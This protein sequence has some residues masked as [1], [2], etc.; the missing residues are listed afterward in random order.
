M[1]KKVALILAIVMILGM[2]PMN[3]FGRVWH[4]ATPTEGWTTVW[5]EIPVA[6][7]GI[8]RSTAYGVTG[9]VLGPLVRPLDAGNIGPVTRLFPVQLHG[10]VSTRVDGGQAIGN[11]RLIDNRN[12]TLLGVADVP[13][14]FG[15][16]FTQSPLPPLGQTQNVGAGARFAH[17]EWLFIPEHTPLGGISTVGGF[18]VRFIPMWNPATNE[19]STTQGWIDLRGWSGWNT[20]E[21]PAVPATFNSVIVN[22]Q[23]V[24]RIPL[25]VNITAANA[26]ITVLRHDGGPDWTQGFPLINNQ[27]LLGLPEDVTLPAAQMTLTAGGVNN[28][29]HVLGINSLILTEA[30][31]NRIRNIQAGDPNQLGMPNWPTFQAVTLR[32]APDLAT[33]TFTETLPLDAGLEFAFIID[34]RSDFVAGVHTAATAALTGNLIGTPMIGPT[35][36]V[37]VASLLAA[38][39][40]TAVLQEA[41]R[42]VRRAGA[43]GQGMWHQRAAG[44]N[45]PWELVTQ[46]SAAHNQHLPLPATLNIAFGEWATVGVATGGAL[47]GSF[48]TSATTPAGNAV[49]VEQN[50]V[51]ILS[52]EQVLAAVT[53]TGGQ[54]SPPPLWAIASSGVIGSGVEP[55]HVAGLATHGYDHMLQTHLVTNAVTPGVLV[56]VTNTTGISQ[57]AIA[58]GIFDRSA[59][60]WDVAPGRHGTIVSSAFI[61]PAGETTGAVLGGIPQIL[62]AIGFDPIPAGF[63]ASPIYNQILPFLGTAT[64][65]TRVG[66]GRVWWFVDGVN[67]TGG[68]GIPVETAPFPGGTVLPSGQIE[69]EHNAIPWTQNTRDHMRVLAG[70]PEFGMQGDNLGWFTLRLVAPQHYAWNIAGFGSNPFVPGNAPI[71]VEGL[72]Q[73]NW[74][75]LQFVS[76][77]GNTAFRIGQRQAA[78]NHLNRWGTGAND[79][80][81]AQSN[82]QM[83]D[84]VYQN[85]L[86]VRINAG[87]PGPGVGGAQPL[88]AGIVSASNGVRNHTAQI[89][90]IEMLGLQ[91]FPN[92]QA[93]ISGEVAINASWGWSARVGTTPWNTFREVHAWG[94]PIVVGNRG[95]AE[96]NFTA[97]GATNMQTGWLGDRRTGTGNAANNNPGNMNLAHY[98][99]VVSATVTLEESQPGILTTNWAAPL[100]FRFNQHIDGQGIRLLGAVIN[101]G[102]NAAGNDIINNFQ[103]W[104]SAADQRFAAH[105][106]HIQ[107]DPSS[108]FVTL[109]VQSVHNI[110]HRA[111]LTARFYFSVEADFVNKFDTDEI[112]V[113]I[114]GIG[115]AALSQ[116]ARRLTIGHAVDPISV[117]LDGEVTEVDTDALFGV[118]QQRLSDVRVT[119]Y[120][121]NVLQ[122]NEELWLYLTDSTSAR[123]EFFLD[124]NRVRAT[125]DPAAVAAGLVLAPVRALEHPHPNYQRHG[126]AVT[127]QRQPVS[128]ASFD[129]VFSDL[130]VTGRLIPGRE[131]MVAVSGTRIAQN[132]QTV[133]TALHFG[134]GL[135]TTIPQLNVGTFTA[136][137]YALPILREGTGGLT[138]A[139]GGI[140]GGRSLALREGM[141]PIDTFVSGEAETVENPFFLMENP[142][143]SRFVVSMLNPRVFA[144]F[145]GGEID[146]NGADQTV[147]FSGFDANGGAV[148]VQLTVGST[149]AIV[150]GDTVDIAN[151]AGASGPIGSISTIN[152]NGRTFVPLRFLA[153]A[154]LLDI[155]WQAGTVFLES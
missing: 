72:P 66:T 57:P 142:M 75:Y 29:S 78:Y 80:F 155:R 83:I 14:L 79:G 50:N 101:A 51:Q 38:D 92:A 49:A 52:P 135:G 99:G 132:D 11:H 96:L 136:L 4:V 12:S 23:N 118:A 98:R 44:S 28:F 64:Q 21:T 8:G 128:G 115:V 85:V 10:G 46:W 117:T 153:N 103:G 134:Q 74:H 120:N 55:A 149:N 151:F 124:P 41:G 141:L 140:F 7:L 152:V 116:D 143:D 77:A 104:L 60:T 47:A 111:R 36:G 123:T 22:N 84:G 113:D 89:G 114:S 119:V 63:T 39:G 90:V 68:A 26:A 15:S 56:N 127:I 87:H 16:V 95:A 20:T 102:T 59:G 82:W 18:E 9:D 13:A 107:I 24:I 45:D 71:N 88:P 108:V 122:N 144:D 53:G 33:F 100:E 3:V 32:Y 58:P 40:A 62:G 73:P 61:S 147:T 6:D 35:I 19:Y 67:F 133:R 76:P 150:N 126:V 37:N 139:P 121:N 31:N 146:W 81:Q 125:P 131:Y 43:Y 91:L 148:E 129:I 70:R 69:W 154:F 54:P 65:P 42:D 27:S 2:L 137:P 112:T 1:K 138:L 5:I 48:G 94:T 97:D 130:Y 25:R 109:P 34:W 93:P 17:N 145:I 110:N 30:L 106:S 86:Y 105:H